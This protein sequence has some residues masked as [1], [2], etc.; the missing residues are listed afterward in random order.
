MNSAQFDIFSGVHPDIRAVFSRVKGFYA[1][2]QLEEGFLY[3]CCRPFDLLPDR[4]R[5]PWRVERIAAA[6]AANLQAGYLQRLEGLTGSLL[7]VTAV[8]LDACS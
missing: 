1:S 6:I 5:V 8:G 3:T 2:Q 4:R 7:R